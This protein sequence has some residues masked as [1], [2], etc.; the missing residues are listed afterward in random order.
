MLCYLTGLNSKERKVSTRKH[1]SDATELEF[2]TATW[3]RWAPHASESM[4]QEVPVLA[5]TTDS[6]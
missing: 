3:P 5:G 2:K 1:G 4:K 6:N